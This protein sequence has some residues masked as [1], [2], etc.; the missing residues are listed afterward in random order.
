M[1]VAMDIRQKMKLIRKLEKYTQKDFATLLQ[2]S[3]EGYQKI[4]YGVYH[5][6]YLVLQQLCN[7]F[8]EYTVWL[9]TADIDVCTIKNQDFE[10]HF[11]KQQGE[12]I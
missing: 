8:P 9:M 5:P 10:F 3:V 2:I 12:I 11:F 6:R 4:E 1:L 7:K